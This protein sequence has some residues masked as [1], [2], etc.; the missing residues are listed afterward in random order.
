MTF[1]ECAK[2]QAAEIAQAEAGRVDYL[3][4]RALHTARYESMLEKAR[5]WEPPT[6]DHVEMKTFMIEQIEI[7]MP[8]ST[9]EPSVPEAVTP[10]LWKSA[11]LAKCRKQL[12]RARE[13]LTEEQE[14]AAKRTAWGKALK[15]SL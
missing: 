12:A 5:A 1:G 15:G 4:T 14:R 2:A 8:C 6:P 3:K 9:Y 13:R 7:S 10:E 11:K